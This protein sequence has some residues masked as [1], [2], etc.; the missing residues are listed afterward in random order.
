MSYEPTH[1]K[2]WTRP[3][4]YIGA[5]WPEYYVFLGRHRDSDILTESNYWSG[6]KAIGGERD[7][8]DGT[9]LV[10]RIQ[11]NHWAVGWVEWIAIHESCE[12]ALRL[13]DGVMER[14]ADYPVVD[15]DDLSEREDKCVYDYWKGESLKYRVDLCREHGAS[16]FA[17]RRADSV[18]EGVYDYLRYLDLRREDCKLKEQP[19][20]SEERAR[21]FFF[22]LPDV[23]A[24]ES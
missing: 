10:I 4:C 16:I 14:L 11:E 7:T 3:D 1:L 2:R 12:E 18:P 5:E 17:A 6:L 24:I 21:E 13:A 19:I 22:N 20:V 8:E 23:E 15:D 9:N